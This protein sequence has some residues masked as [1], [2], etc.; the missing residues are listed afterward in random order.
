[1]K[2]TIKCRK[3]SIIENTIR[4]FNRHL[5]KRL[6]PA[7]ELS[8]DQGNLIW[9]IDPGY[10][11]EAYSIADRPDG[12]VQLKG[13]SSMAILF[14]TGKILHTAD[15]SGGVFKIGRWRGKVEPYAGYRIVYLAA[16]FHN[17]Y[18]VAPFEEI[19]EYLEDLALWGY[20][21]LI[22]WIDKHHFQGAEDPKLA[23][24]VERARKIY[25]AGAAVGLKPIICGLANEGYA[26]TP[27]PLKATYPGRS[28]YYCEVCPST[29]A[30]RDLIQ[31]NLRD[32]LEWFKDLPIAGLFQGCYD[33]G[34]CACPEC[35]PWGCNGMFK[36]TK[37][38][39]ELFRQ[40]F[41]EGKLIYFTWLFNYKG[42]KEWEGLDERMAAGDGQ[43]IDMLMADSHEDFPQFPLIHGVPGKRPLLNFP[44]I[45]MW[46]M[47]PWGGF[48]AN[49]LIKRLRTLWGQAGHIL[50]GGMPYSEGIYEDINKIVCSAFYW[51]GHNETDEIL[52]EYA[53]FECGC[54]DSEKFKKLLDILEQNHVTDYNL[55][56]T[57]GKYTE[58][59]AL[60]LKPIHSRPNLVGRKVFQYDPEDGYRIARELDNQA[61]EWARKSWRWRIIYLRALIDYRLKLND[62][63]FDAITDRALDELSGI[64]HSQGLAE[65]KVA[66]LTLESASSL[67]TSATV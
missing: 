40:Y 49:P 15:F 55:A 66:P 42:E 12:T 29:Q 10:P 13:G 2:L 50:S 38:S 44:E 8:L 51:Q 26:N 16:H 57:V 32:T 14:G 47:H 20:N 45:S 24:F 25:K 28:F 61:P 22:M 64:F 35:F 37:R 9:E 23:L 41:P 6:C 48:G 60:G 21:S 33:Q 1:M 39:A 43:W 17:Y 59:A 53:A 34:G 65:Y 5:R 67:R 36:T 54:G 56:E 62:L 30:G 31:K 52:R 63:E 19:A 11:E 18:H 58:Y 7:V 27:E 3:D 4:I 46:G